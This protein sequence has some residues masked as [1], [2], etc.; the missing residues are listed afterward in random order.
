MARAGMLAG[1]ADPDSVPSEETAAA[2]RESV[3]QVLGNMELARRHLAGEKVDKP[4]KATE[5]TVLD[6]MLTESTPPGP[7]R[8][9]LRAL[10]RLN[11]TVLELI[12]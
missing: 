6:A 2:V 8:A 12:G 7:R 3:A 1:R 4:E 5:T 9:A 10:H 11:R